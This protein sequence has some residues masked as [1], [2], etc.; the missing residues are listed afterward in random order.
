MMGIGICGGIGVGA[1]VDSEGGGGGEDSRN[2]GGGGGGGCM[3]F[4]GAFRGFLA[5]GKNTALML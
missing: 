2:S 5:F 4:G 3:W 1:R